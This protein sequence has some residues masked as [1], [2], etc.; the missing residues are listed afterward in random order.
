MK[1]L[2]RQIWL[3]IAL[4]LTGDADTAY[5]IAKENG[6]SVSDMPTPGMEIQY[7]GGVVNMQVLD[8]YASHD[9]NPATGVADKDESNFR[10]FDYTFDFTFE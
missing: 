9:I 4:V 7:S 1:A 10:I 8:F 6:M 5:D 3:D 2:A